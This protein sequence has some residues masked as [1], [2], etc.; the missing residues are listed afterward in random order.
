MN[1]PFE[2]TVRRFLTDF[3]SLEISRID[4]EKMASE[5][6]KALLEQKMKREQKIAEKGVDPCAVVDMNVST[7]RRPL[8][9]SN[10]EA[11]VTE[12]KKAKM[13]DRFD[14]IFFR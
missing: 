12:P 3:S 5:F 11:K 8:L 13:S 9:E 2:Q 10:Q 4:R 14:R 7:K 6:Q 1:S